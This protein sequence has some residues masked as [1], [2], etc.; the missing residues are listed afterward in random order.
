MPQVGSVLSKAYVKSQLSLHRNKQ[1]LDYA[2]L[3]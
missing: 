2:I 3:L 1:A